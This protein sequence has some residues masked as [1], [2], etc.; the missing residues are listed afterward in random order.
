MLSNDFKFFFKKFFIIIIIIVYF[1]V[2]NIEN[3]KK[4]KYNSD[5]L[6]KINNFEKNHI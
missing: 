2:F 4:Q 5:L 3:Y 1:I 6:L